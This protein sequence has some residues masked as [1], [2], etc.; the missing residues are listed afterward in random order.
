MDEEVSLP[1]VEPI[2]KIRWIEVNY[3]GTT[4]YILGADSEV[5]AVEEEE[6]KQPE[7]GQENIR[8]QPVQPAQP[9]QPPQPPQPLPSSNDHQRQRNSFKQPEARRG[10]RDQ[11]DAPAKEQQP[12]QRPNRVARAAEKDESSGCE[13]LQVC[14]AIVGVPENPFKIRDYSQFDKNFR[15]GRAALFD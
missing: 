3:R 6:E 15:Y 13:D 4:R 8:D 14:Q 12:A 1:A 5:R 10:P 7:G 2:A 9:A 11:V